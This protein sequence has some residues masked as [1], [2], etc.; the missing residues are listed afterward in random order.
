MAEL[1]SFG[2]PSLLVP[3]PHAADDH[4][5]RNA[6]VFAAAGAA[7]LLRESELHPEQLAQAVREILLNPEH[8]SAMRQ[9]ARAQDTPECA[10]RL[11]DLIEAGLRR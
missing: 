2:V 10:E 5:T 1:A 9:A 4:Q 11:A 8:E 7:R 6:E 3:Y